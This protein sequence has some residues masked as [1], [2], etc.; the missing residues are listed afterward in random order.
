MAG[1][2]HVVGAGLSGLAAAVALAAGGREV[3]LY[4]AAPQAGGRCR[5]YHDSTLDLTI[6]NGNHL[7][8]SA[9]QT[10]LDYL[11]AIGA[12]D[13]LAGP[14][15]AAFPFFDLR[16]RERW[17]LRPNDGPLPWWVFAPSRRVPGSRALDY[18]APLGIL[19]ARR[20]MPIGEV[21]ACSGALYDRLWGPVLLAGLNTA[22]AEGSTRLAAAMIRETLAAG[23]RECRPLVAR[24]GLSQAFVDPALAML[25]RKGAT[26]AFGQ[27]LRGLSFAADRIDGLAFA[28]H[29]ETL[30]PEDSAVLAVPAWTAAEILPGLTAPQR[31]SAIVNLHYRIAPPAGA[32]LFLGLVGGLAEW[33]FTFENRI[34]VTI[35]GADRLL[36]E[37]RESLAQRVWAE[38]GQALGI[39]A[40]L[41]VWQ[42]VKEKRATFAATPAENALRPAA[43]TDWRNL[44]LAGDWTQTGLP[45]TIEGAIRSGH[46]AAALL[47][48]QG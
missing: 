42:V 44:V 24:Q 5:S 1:R 33:I 47:S 21:M 10:A 28:G 37:D 19:M 30:G 41:P 36:Q 48:A 46:R 43:E 38:I 40:P 8:L 2:V 35:S 39:D 34:S 4:E 23:G 13:A 27:R 25:R 18:R 16:S 31:H 11:R 6:D 45:A 12:P 22:P 17:T 26:I 15:E 9:N 32:P 3:R 14:D 29:T 20:D 7:L